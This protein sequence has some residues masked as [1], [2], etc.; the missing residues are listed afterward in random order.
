MSPPPRLSRRA[1]TIGGIAGATA[2]VVLAAI[3]EVPKLLRHR[4][5]GEYADLV[6]R[7]DDPEKAAIVGRTLPEHAVL[8]KEQLSELKT[9]LA[10]SP[11]SDVAV[12]DAKDGRLREADGWVLPA[13][14]AALCVLA[15]Q[16]V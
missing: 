16:A 12:A 4:A 5:R 11:L 14:V 8:S 13:T 15:A 1:V 9:A 3:Y 7:L 10:S 2:A 6:N